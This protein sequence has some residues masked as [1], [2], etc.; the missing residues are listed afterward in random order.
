MR[1]AT[2]AWLDGR[3]AASCASRRDAYQQ[4][5]DKGRHSAICIERGRR[6]G[7]DAAKRYERT[8]PRPTSA[9]GD[10][11]CPLS[12]LTE[13]ELDQGVARR[14]VDRVRSLVA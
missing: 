6:A 13:D 5:A 11:A 10:P 14:A 4:A 1:N 12:Y 8:V 9:N 7:V 3:Y 2:A